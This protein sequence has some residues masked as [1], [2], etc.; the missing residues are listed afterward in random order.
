[1]TALILK[2]LFNE[3]LPLINHLIRVQTPWWIQPVG[4]SSTTEQKSTWVPVKFLNWLWA[5]VIRKVFSCSDQKAFFC[6]K[7]ITIWKIN[8]NFTIQKRNLLLLAKVQPLS[9][10]LPRVP[11]KYLIWLS[12]SYWKYNYDERWGDNWSELSFIMV[13]ISYLIVKTK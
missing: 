6:G 8:L 5:L 1:M 7:K 9:R 4:Q 11:G 12:I 2:T 13:M 10:N 3:R